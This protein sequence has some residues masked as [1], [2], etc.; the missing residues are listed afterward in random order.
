V[1]SG[2]IQDIDR[3]TVSKVPILG[4]I[5]LLGILFRKEEGRR[6]R[7]ELV[8]LVTPRLVDDSEQATTGYQYSPSPNAQNL[9]NK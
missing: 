1:L 8:V 7:N 6:A 3:T 4:D 9:L 5:P 2:I